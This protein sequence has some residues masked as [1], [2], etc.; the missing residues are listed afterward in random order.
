MIIPLEIKINSLNLTK[1]MLNR[2]MIMKEA[3]SQSALKMQER[4][5]RKMAFRSI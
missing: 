5:N 2:A 4:A 1:A 3:K